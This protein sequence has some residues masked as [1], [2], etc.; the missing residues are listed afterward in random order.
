METCLLAS[1]KKK[2]KKSP[3]LGTCEGEEERWRDWSSQ[4]SRNWARRFWRDFKRQ[5]LWLFFCVFNLRRRHAGSGSGW[6][7]EWEGSVKTLWNSREPRSVSS[8]PCTKQ[9][10]QQ[11]SRSAALLLHLHRYF[12]R[13]RHFRF[14]I[15]VCVR[16]R[17]Y[18]CVRV[19]VCAQATAEHCCNLPFTPVKIRYFAPAPASAKSSSLPLPA[20]V[21]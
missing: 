2:E 20:T 10:L 3:D 12:A 15:F 14:F 5:S 11:T 13:Q 18:V 6:E 9:L 8:S 16:M 7:W 21:L 17:A 4:F 1:Q 19:R